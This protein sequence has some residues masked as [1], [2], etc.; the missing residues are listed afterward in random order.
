LVFEKAINR[1]VK[2]K[3]DIVVFDLNELTLIDEVAQSQILERYLRN[4]AIKINEARE[5]IGLPSVPEGDKFFE[6][7]P[8]TTAEQNSQAGETRSRDQQ[9]TA[10]N[11]DSST[12]VAGRNPQGSGSKE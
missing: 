6:P 10:N 7:K 12:T 9:R 2:E 1:I 3:T 8:Q 4:Q 5:Q 11:S